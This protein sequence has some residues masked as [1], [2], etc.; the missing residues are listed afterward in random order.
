MCIKAPKIKAPAPAPTMS[1]ETVDAAGQAARDRERL[2]RMAA[3]GRNSTI[4]TDGAAPAVAA[5][6]KT[7]LGS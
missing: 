6:G 4:L 7:L 5:A 2:R 1:A 3:G